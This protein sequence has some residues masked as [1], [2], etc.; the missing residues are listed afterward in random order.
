MIRTIAMPIRAPPTVLKKDSRKGNEQMSFDM[1]RCYNGLKKKKK[2][3][4]TKKKKRVIDVACL[5]L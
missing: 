2:L 4:I 5:D 3:K 1:Q